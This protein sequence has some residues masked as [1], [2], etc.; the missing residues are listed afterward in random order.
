[1]CCVGAE[2]LLSNWGTDVVAA[3]AKEV[4]EGGTAGRAGSG[5][6]GGPGVDGGVGRD[7]RGREQRGGVD[8]KGTM[9]GM[10]IDEG[11][12]GMKVTNITY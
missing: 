1:V 12:S 7:Q 4:E 5:R 9:T 2:L 11:S 3:G 8:S 10:K 6:W